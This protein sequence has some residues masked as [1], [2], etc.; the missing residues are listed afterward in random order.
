MNSSE[1]TVACR[2]IPARQVVN[3]KQEQSNIVYKRSLLTL[4]FIISVMDPLHFDVD[5]DPT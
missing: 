1:K 2:N 5:P 3:S 4:I